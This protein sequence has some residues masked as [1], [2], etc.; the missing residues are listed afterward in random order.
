MIL[1]AQAYEDQSASPLS[2][3]FLETVFSLSPELTDLAI[4]VG[5]TPLLWC[6]VTD[7]F[8]E[9]AEDSG[10]HSCTASLLPIELSTTP[11]PG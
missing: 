7:A 8:C 4:L 11:H 10:P 1:N 3:L 6:S 9:C 5:S 2:T